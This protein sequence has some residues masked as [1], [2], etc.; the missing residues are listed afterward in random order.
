MKLAIALE[1]KQDEFLAG[2]VHHT[3]EEWQ[4]VAEMLRGMNSN[5][6]KLAKNFLSWLSEQKM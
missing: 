3:G 1:T 6:L 4:D 5:Q 2:S